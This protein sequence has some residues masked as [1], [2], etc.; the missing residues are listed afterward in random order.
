M[1]EKATT[2]S[3]VFLVNMIELQFAMQSTWTLA[4]GAVSVKR[5]MCS[6]E[7]KLFSSVKFL[8]AYGLRLSQV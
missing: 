3:Y 8:L 1:T 6:E 4:L 7:V 2:F 5:G